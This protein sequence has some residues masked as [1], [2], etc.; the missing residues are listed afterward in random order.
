MDENTKMEAEVKAEKSSLSIPGAIVIVGILIAGAILLSNRPNTPAP[1]NT[2]QPQTPTSISI[3]PVNASDHILG[4]PNAPITIVEYSDLE[5]PFCKMFQSTMHS[6]MDTYGK[7]GQ[8]AWV[9][10]NFTVHSLAPNEADAAECANAEG[11]NTLYWNYIDDIFATTTSTDSLDPAVLPAVAGELGLNVTKFNT[12]LSGNTYLS[13]VEQ[14][15]NDA[16][17]AGG[18]GTPYSVMI[19]K[20]A[21]PA[22]KATAIENYVIQNNLAQ[23]IILSSDNKNIALNGAIPLANVTAILDLILK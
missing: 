6:I 17:A 23:N 19:L 13:L 3:K 1:T 11:G 15:T 9:Y 4:D 12:C 8:V 18:D 2:A 21:L 5:C 16:E 20:T 22:E 14:E 7:N 10:R